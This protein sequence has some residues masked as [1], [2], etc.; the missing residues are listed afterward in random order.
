MA[1]ELTLHRPYLPALAEAPLYQPDARLGRTLRLGLSLSAALVFGLGGLM[2]LVPIAGAVVAPGQ[3]S[4]ASHV[5]QLG[6]PSGGVVADILVRDGDHVKA[7]QP[8]MRLENT[9]SGANA[10]LTGENVDQLLAR[11]ARLTAERDGLG[12]IAFPKELTDRAGDPNIAALMDAERKTFALR[13]QSRSG[14]VAQLQQRVNQAQA[15]IRSSRSRADSYNRQAS[16]IGEELDATRALYEKRY[17]TLDR[18]NSLERSASGLAAEASSARQGADAAS[19]RIGEL[20]AQMASVQQDSRSAAAA[21]LMEVERQITEL[22]RVQV[23]ADDSFDKSV[24]RAPQAGVVDKLAFRTVGGIVPA[25]ETIMEIVPDNDRLVVEASV[26]PADIDQIHEGQPATVR[27][28]AFSNR[29]TPEVTG[30][31]THV[32]ASRVDDR[33]TGSAFYRVT[34]SFT[35]RE[36]KELGNVALKPGMP[37]EA[38]VRTRDRT[39]LSYILRPLTDQWSRAFREN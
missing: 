15:D 35:A 32:S 6:H 24:I 38:F 12:A 30:E 26:S 31:V 14:L 11:A 28:S 2:A 37:A 7:G 27:F 21:E 20:R 39:M 29:T 9:V 10:Q 13:R 1:S 4:M 16:L 19:A 33:A 22:R 8:L 3:V 5:K 34:I 23:A 25:G 36:L 18:L 17:T